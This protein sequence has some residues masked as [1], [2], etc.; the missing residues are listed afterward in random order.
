METILPAPLLCNRVFFPSENLI[1]NERV[2]GCHIYGKSFKLPLCTRRH[3]GVPNPR[4]GHDSSVSQSFENWKGI[5]LRLLESFNICKSLSWNLYSQ[6]WQISTWRKSSP[7]SSQVYRGVFLHL[8]TSR[9]KWNMLLLHRR[10]T[11][12][13][14]KEGR[15][16]IEH[17]PETDSGQPRDK[18]VGVGTTEFVIDVSQR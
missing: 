14:R 6:S 13:R 5:P 1:G 3:L 16:T 15:L 7:S 17:K 2:G 8:A 4:F 9:V 12:Y 18:S 10:K 11:T